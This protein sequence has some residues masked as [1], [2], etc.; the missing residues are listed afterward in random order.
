MFGLAAYAPLHVP[1]IGQ[2]SWNDVTELLN[3]PR[4]WLRRLCGV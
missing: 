4:N 1:F 3:E 2:T